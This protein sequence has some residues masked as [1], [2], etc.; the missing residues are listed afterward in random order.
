MEAVRQA[1]ETSQIDFDPQRPLT[2]GVV[3]ATVW[4]WLANVGVS[5]ASGGL[6]A[7]LADVNELLDYLERVQL[8]V[9]RPEALYLKGQILQQQ[10]RPDEAQGIWQQARTESEAMGERRMRWRILT[11]LAEIVGDVQEAAELR[12]SAREIVAYIA[13]NAGRPEIRQ[14]FLNRPDVRRLASD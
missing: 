2:G 1:N 10:K 13:G 4:I 5:L 3:F 7:A 9:Y 14:S 11:G 12:Q 6:A 8:P